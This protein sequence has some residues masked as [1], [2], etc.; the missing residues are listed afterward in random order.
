MITVTGCAPKHTRHLDSN[1][2][3]RSTRCLTMPRNIRCLTMPGDLVVV[4]VVVVGGGG[5]P[6][7]SFVTHHFRSRRPRGRKKKKSKKGET[8]RKETH[9]RVNWL[10]C[11]E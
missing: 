4:V 2:D 9:T 8:G 7:P 11:C 1:R 10:P 6:H 3:P 5:Y